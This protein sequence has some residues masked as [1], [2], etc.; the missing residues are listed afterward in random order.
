VPTSGFSRDVQAP[1]VDARP[2]SHL[3][4]RSHS[5]SYVSKSE[6]PASTPTPPPDA[7]S[8]PRAM[9]NPPTAPSFTKRLLLARQKELQERIARS[10]LELSKVTT[11]RSSPNTTPT[12][13]P[14][15]D[16]ASGSFRLEVDKD[17][18][19]VSVEDNLRRLVL[20]SKRNRAGKVSSLNVDA[21]AESDSEATTASLLGSCSTSSFSRESSSPIP[22][23]AVVDHPVGSC[24][25]DQDALADLAVSFITEAIQTVKPLNANPPASLVKLELAAK[26]QK[27]E[28]QIAESKLLMAKLNTAQSKQEKDAILRAMRERSRCVFCWMCDKVAAKGIRYPSFILMIG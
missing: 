16:P 18:N 2:H 3:R 23:P 11:T 20:D 10:K 27:L 28:Q 7:P 9:M 4:S 13:T 26:Q 6:T 5:L 1:V 8:A 15:P 12:S 22:P 24:V 14:A 21:S 17:S 19:K 25:Q